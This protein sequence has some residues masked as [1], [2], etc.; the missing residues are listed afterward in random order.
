[1]PTQSMRRANAASRKKS[2]GPI[3]KNTGPVWPKSYHAPPRRPY[4]PGPIVAPDV[5]A[6]LRREQRAIELDLLLLKR[7][8]AWQDVIDKATLGLQRKTR[9]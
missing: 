3:R 2:L 6:E 7:D 5:I 4:P 9:L 1:M 8:L